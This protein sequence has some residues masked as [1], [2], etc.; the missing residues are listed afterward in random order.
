MRVATYNMESFGDDRFDPDRL[1]PRLKALRPRLSELKADIL[2]L[3]EVNAQK[4]QG[5]QAREFLA[6]EALLSGTEYREYE[7]G[8]STRP[9]AALPADRHNLMVL[10]RYPI[11]DQK[12][13]FQTHLQVPV[14]RPAHADPYTEAPQPITFDR[15]ILQV[16][17]DI[18]ARNT[19]HVFVV[20]LRAPIAAPIP[21]GKLSVSSWRSVPAW[22]EGYFLSALKRTAQALD[23]RLAVDKVFEIDPAGMI[24]VAGDFNASGDASALRLACA[25]PEDTGNPSLHHR[26]LIQVDALLPPDARNTIIHKGRGQTL[27]HILVSPSLYETFSSVSVFNSGLADEVLEAETDAKNASF[28]AAVCAEFNL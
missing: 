10:S 14:W 9:N 11:V 6:L 22:A 8:H 25:D 2:C 3:Q 1:A 15:P 24:L 26:Q 18:G 4:R 16:E 7:I 12:V 19:L 13:L 20:H 17:I 21:G 28:H 23:L 27:D 5:A